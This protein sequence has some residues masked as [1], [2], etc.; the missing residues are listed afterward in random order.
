MQ[1]LIICADDFG[2]RESVSGGI[3]DLVSR[4]RIQATS[5]LVNAPHFSI[6]ATALAGLHQQVAIGLHFDLTE[7]PFASVY[8]QKK[9][10]QPYAI[11]RLLLKQLFHL[12]DKQ[13]IAS[14]LAAQLNRFQNAFGFPP[15]FIDGHLHVHQL[16]TVLPCILSAAKAFP[17]MSVRYVSTD[18]AHPSAKIK[19]WVLKAMLPLSA[20]RLLRQQTINFAPHFAGL[21]NFNTTESYRS[22]FQFFLERIPEKTLIMCHPARAYPEE[23]DPWRIAEYDYFSSDSFLTDLREIVPRLV[24]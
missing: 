6:A 7:F 14:E 4:R 9:G 11:S 8:A 15:D 22:V 17:N 12:I 10:I 19:S 13:F 16:P 5:C 21:Y 24:A 20:K 18:L 3:L 2:L 23:P 1:K